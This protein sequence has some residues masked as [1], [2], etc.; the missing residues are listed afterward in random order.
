MEKISF[1]LVASVFFIAFVVKRS[2]QL[3]KEKM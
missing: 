3:T 2:H 1:F